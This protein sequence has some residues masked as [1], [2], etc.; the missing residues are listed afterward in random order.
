MN[1]RTATTIT[2]SI[3]VSLASLGISAPGHAQGVADGPSDQLISGVLDQYQ[4]EQDA[5]WTTDPSAPQSQAL[6]SHAETYSERVNER[7]RDELVKNGTPITS[8]TTNVSILSSK[9]DG[10]GGVEVSV[11]TTTTF[12]YGG[13]AA[14]TIPGI[15]TDRHLITLSPTG[16]GNLAVSSDT[17]QN[18][19]DSG[20]PNDL[21]ADYS[22]QESS[23]DKSKSKLFG[24]ADTS[25]STEDSAAKSTTAA[26]GRLTFEPMQYYAMKWTQPPNDGDTPGDFNPDY[27]QFSSNCANF[28][29]QILVAGGWHYDGGI[30]PYDT[31]NWSPNLTGP[32]GASRTWMNSAYQY[33]YAKNHSFKYRS[34]IW[35]GA[36]GDLFYIDWDPNGVADGS[37]DHVMFVT[38]AWLDGQEP[39]ISQ[40]TP[41]RSAILLSQSIANAKAQGKTKI[42]WYA[43]TQATS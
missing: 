35:E 23:S 20:D 26:N 32:S 7:V 40:K 19:E 30:N 25:T 1:H 8:A 27:P 17:L 31:S 11:E 14:S 39:R 4:H 2:T 38:Y 29:S 3:L 41:N 22:P 21:P 33:T 24:G 6:A 10:N 16:D 34:N 15:S 43:L 37:I 42:V 18:G 28:V 5:L 9:P 36:P 13:S 12:F